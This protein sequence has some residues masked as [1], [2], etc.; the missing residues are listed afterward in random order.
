[1]W[2]GM[3]G[4]PA[5]H[6]VYLNLGSQHAN[7]SQYA[8]TIRWSASSGLAGGVSSTGA[9]RWQAF[10]SSEQLDVTSARRQPRSTPQARVLPS[11]FRTA[12]VRGIPLQSLVIC[13]F[14]GSGG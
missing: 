10:A 12:P 11:E 1:M 3:Y 14:G 8:A 13:T 5:R 2:S 4:L 7:Q 9:S 6:P